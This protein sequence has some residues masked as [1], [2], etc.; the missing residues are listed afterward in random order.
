M[1]DSN[2]INLS[3]S[4]DENK[5]IL[6]DETIDKPNESSTE[7][8]QDVNKQSAGSLK[9]VDISDLIEDADHLKTKSSDNGDDFVIEDPKPKLAAADK[10]DDNASTD[11]KRPSSSVKDDDEPALEM[12]N[13]SSDVLDEE[14][15]FTNAILC[16]IDYYV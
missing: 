16:I 12:V 6:L 7:S 13:F 9:A 8:D 5:T 10:Q 3:M 1:D 11:V 4:G 14:V 2:E 15:S